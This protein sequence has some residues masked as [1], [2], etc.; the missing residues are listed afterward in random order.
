[1]FFIPTKPIGKGS[2]SINHTFDNVTIVPKDLTNLFSRGMF[3]DLFNASYRF[4]NYKLFSENLSI[5]VGA[6][7][8]IAPNET[9][10]DPQDQEGYVFLID[11]LPGVQEKIDNITAAEG[12]IIITDEEELEYADIS[13]CTYLVAG[14]DNDSGN[15]VK[16][17]INNHLIIVEN[18][19]R[20]GKDLTFY[21]NL[22][23]GK[24]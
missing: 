20:F 19:R 15:E 10:P 13:S 3:K 5:M 7:S 21:Y 16:D 24:T 1:M 14:I 11:D 22:D 17:R 12:V 6:L 4:R 23:G 18:T 2:E 8:Y 9:V